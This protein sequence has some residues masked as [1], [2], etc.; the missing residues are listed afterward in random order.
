MLDLR[1][2]TGDISRID[3]AAHRDA[4]GSIN[5]TAWATVTLLPEL[6]P[7]SLQIE[8]FRPMRRNSLLGFCRVR[9]PSGVIFH[10]CSVHCSNGRFW[11]APPARPQMS[12]EGVHLRDAH[13]SKFLYVQI[14]SFSSKE[15]RDR[16]SEAIVGALRAS[17]PEAFDLDPTQEI[18]ADEL[19]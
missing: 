1:N 12:R 16:F 6:C 13:T 14:I 17:H 8:E 4:P 3:E 10:D 7:M 15:V 11:A 5:S 18:D 19:V 2:D 9:M